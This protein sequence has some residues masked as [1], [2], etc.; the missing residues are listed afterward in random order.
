MKSFTNPY[1]I[2]FLCVTLFF[3]SC[4]KDETPAYSGP[5]N[6]GI[7]ITN[8]GPFQSGS[9]TI[10]YYNPGKQIVTQD[11]FELIN[12]K[13]LG[14]VVQSLSTYNGNTYIVVNNAAKVEVVDNTT[15]QSL[16]TI[17]GFQLPRYFLGVNSGKAYVS[18]WAGVVNIVDLLSNTITG[19]IPTRTGPDLMV[20]A[21]SYV[22]VLNG[23]GFDVDSTVTVINYVTDQV[24]STIQ[25]FNRPSGIV[26]DASGKIW[27]MCSGKGFNGYPAEGDTKAHLLRIDPSNLEVDLDIPFGDVSMHPEKLVTNKAKNVLFFQHNGGIYKINTT[28]SGAQPEMVLQHP[29]LSALTF[30]SANNFLLASDPVDFQGNGWLIRFRADD[31]TT[32]DSIQTGIIPGC[33]V[34]NN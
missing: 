23:G 21:G 10:T 16:A 9:G 24:V 6:D 4:K 13:P 26:E 14:N 5:F 33:I 19:T 32:I 25:V 8:E 12:G 18:D 7:L 28:F 22:Y 1:S 34:V 29:R 2:I 3:I 20:K 27:I 31:G 30:D 11:I 15:F 17:T